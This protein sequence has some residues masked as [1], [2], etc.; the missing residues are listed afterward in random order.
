MLNITVKHVEKFAVYSV[1]ISTQYNSGF[2]FLGRDDVDDL[3]ETFVPYFFRFA[4]EKSEI[5]FV[6]HVANMVG[7]SLFF[8]YDAYLLGFQFVGRVFFDGSQELS[9]FSNA[10]G[11][12]ENDVS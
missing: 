8:S 3:E 11:T 6:M 5:D 10:G 9:V 12:I 1:K 7:V 4:S 2:L